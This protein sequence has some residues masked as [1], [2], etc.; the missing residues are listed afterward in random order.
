MSLG[1]A[2][3]ADAQLAEGCQPGVRALHNPAVTAQTVIAFDAPAGDAALDASLSEMSA[4]ARK[5]VALVRMQFVG[6]A[7][8]SAALA[9]D[10]GD[11]V[12]E[13]LEHHRVM[14]VGARDTEHQWDA[15]PV[16]DEVA[17]AAELAPVGRVGSR[18]RAP[19]GLDTLAPSK[20]TR[21]KSS[22]PAP[23]NSASNSR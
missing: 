10:C 11:G 18:V 23:R 2:L 14:P 5:V 4:A 12:N 15:L 13:F 9:S 8:R 17:L 1:T 22:R 3:E 7:A 19:R 20:L 16:R 6:P 21:L